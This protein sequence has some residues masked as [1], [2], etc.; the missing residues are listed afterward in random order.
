MECLC[1]KKYCIS[2]SRKAYYLHGLVIC[3]GDPVPYQAVLECALKEWLRQIS[4]YRYLIP[5]FYF[6][7]RSPK[8]PFFIYPLS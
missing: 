4:H 1:V 3:V 7:I 5:L 8:Y 6:P 2:P